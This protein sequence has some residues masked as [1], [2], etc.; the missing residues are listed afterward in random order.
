MSV[1]SASVP[2]ELGRRTVILPTFDG[3]SQILPVEF[4]QYVKAPCLKLISATVERASLPSIVKAS[5]S[6]SFPSVPAATVNDITPGLASVTVRP[7]RLTAIFALL[8]RTSTYP[9]VVSFRVSY[10]CAPVPLA[11]KRARSS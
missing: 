11:L 3:R 2:V 9:F 4:S 8:A 6:T 5:N 7:E 10:I 1:V